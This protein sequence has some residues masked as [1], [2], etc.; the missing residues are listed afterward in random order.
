MKA[1][2]AAAAIGDDVEW[3]VY[4]P[5]GEWYL[6]D[7]TDIHGSGHAARVLVWANVIGC[8][9]L[10]RGVEV[11]LAVVH[12][13][14]AL[15]DVRRLNDGHDL[16]HGH[17]CATWLLDVESPALR[18]FSQERRSRVAY[19]CQWHVPSDAEAPAMT[20][21][22]M[23]LKDADGL[24][25]VRLGDLDVSYLR[26]ELARDLVKHAQFLCHHSYA[27]PGYRDDPWAAVKHT[28]CEMN[29]WSTAKQVDW[30]SL[31]KRLWYFVC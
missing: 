12:S 26:T 14:A 18:G 13:A 6:H 16:L 4:R 11:D 10:E 19:C 28:T 30:Q 3:D 8:W 20:A 1:E 7:S 17:R 25:R 22:L 15:H 27:Q 9:M 5:L 23:C 2:C 24:D 29:L 31:R 21:E